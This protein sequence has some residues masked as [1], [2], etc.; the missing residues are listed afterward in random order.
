MYS[1]TLILLTTALKKAS[2]LVIRDFNEIENLLSNESYALDYANKT[3]AKLQEFLHNDISKFKNNYSFLIPPSKHIKN[4]D[5]S[6]TF[7]LHGIIGLE[8]FIKAIPYFAMAIS[9]QRDNKIFASVIYNP[10]TNEIF[11]VEKDNGAFFNQKKVRV[12]NYK[13]TG[14][15]HP[16]ITTDAKSIQLDSSLLS[17]NISISQCKILDLCYVSTNK[18]NTA[19][20]HNNIPLYNV[21]PGILFAQE[22]GLVV[23][24]TINDN[25]INKLVVSNVSV[26]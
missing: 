22:S 17:K 11:S 20:F 2:N 9:L 12:A 13:N 14:I 24:S 8:N 7:I 18:I 26:Y 1:N 10:I 23:D 6:N 15:S 4:K 19:V 21:S 5:E 3:Q 16:S 25:I